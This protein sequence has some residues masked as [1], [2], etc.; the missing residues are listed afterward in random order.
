VICRERDVILVPIERG[1]ASRLQA[2]RASTSHGEAGTITSGIL[3]DC[4][5]RTTGGL[6][7]SSLSAVEN[8][9]SSKGARVVDVV[10]IHGAML[11]AVLIAEW[12]GNISIP[13]GIT[14]VVLF[15]LVWSLLIGAGVSIVHR[16]VPGLRARSV[17]AQF[18]ASHFI[19]AAILLFVV[20]LGFIIGDSLKQILAAGWAL[21]FQ[22]FGHFFGTMALALPLA[23][24]LGVKRE[25]IG[26]TFSIGREFSVAIIS[27]RYGMN[28]AEGRGVLAEYVTGTVIGALLVAILAGALAELHIF[29]ASSLA[30]G[31]GVGSGSMMSAA[32]GALTAQAPDRAKEI[33]ALGAASNLLTT[34]VGT[35]FTLFLSLPCTN[36][37]Y[38]KLEPAL[39]P[40]KSIYRT[41]ETGEVSDALNAMAGSEALPLWATMTTMLVAGTVALFGNWIATKVTPAAALPGLLIMV[42]IAVIGIAIYY[43]ARRTRIPLVCWISVVGILATAPFS[44]TA[45]YISPLVAKIGLLPLVTP[46]LAY[47]G[48]SLAKDLPI[49]RRLGWRIIVVSLVANAGTF[50][51]G[52]LIAEL[53]HR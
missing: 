28:S 39:A 48:L 45:A 18:Q 38:S 37:L 44:P 26:A 31:A 51:F 15:P 14:N 46:V 21:A 17:W 33:A 7:M 24:I 8:I 3:A 43:A 35:Y 20:K 30:M 9:G 1:G 4:R 19:Q 36:W 29:D 12:I 2:I 50:I 49:L 23:I 41:D 47:A 32:V 22:E 5:E 27:E 6:L 25:A 11:A 13:L 40:K 52:T 16:H 42:G 53:F 10:M 34:T